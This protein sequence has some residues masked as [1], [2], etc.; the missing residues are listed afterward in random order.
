MGDFVLK[1]RR[2]LWA[3]QLAVVVDD[4]EQGSPTSCAA[5]TWPTTPRAR[6]CCKSTGAARLRYL[7]TP[8]AGCE[9]RKLS[10]QNGAAAVDLDQP[11]AL[12]Q[13]AG[14]GFARRGRIHH[15]FGVEALAHW[16]QAWSRI[17]N[18]AP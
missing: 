4:A 10:K 15:H 16:V 13:A 5:K 6:S 17:Y 14:S 1:R 18:D 2:R 11:V 9:W 7:H 3:Y 12:N 8:G